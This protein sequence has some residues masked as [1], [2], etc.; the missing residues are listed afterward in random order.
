MGASAPPGQSGRGSL[1]GGLHHGNFATRGS[2]NPGLEVSPSQG[3][4]SLEV[5][6]VTGKRQT[7]HEQIADHAEHMAKFMRRRSSVIR[8]GETNAAD[9]THAELIRRAVSVALSGGAARNSLEMTDKA[10]GSA[11]KRKRSVAQPNQGGTGGLS[12]RA[13]LGTEYASGALAPS[14]QD[15]ESSLQAKQRWETSRWRSKARRGSIVGAA[16]TGEDGTRA[17]FAGGSSSPLRRRSMLRSV[18]R[19]STAAASH[20]DILEATRRI[21]QKGTKDLNTS[22]LELLLG[23]RERLGRAYKFAGTSAIA[24]TAIGGAGV[25]ALLRESTSPAGSL[26]GSKRTTPV[27]SPKPFRRALTWKGKGGGLPTL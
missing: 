12:L 24:S 7:V 21:S 1:Q 13:S 22:E 25:G 19:R 26:A 9:R 11:T 18:R 17:S 6:N 27:S 5:Q 23:I 4:R 20:E 10:T 8:M 14:M 2:L 16:P 3:R 15:I